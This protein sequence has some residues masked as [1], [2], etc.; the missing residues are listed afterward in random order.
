MSS[1]A[2]VLRNIKNK[3]VACVEEYFFVSCTQ[4]TNAITKKTINFH[5]ANFLASSSAN[6]YPGSRANASRFNHL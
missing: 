2:K 1:V 5:Q 6:K 4:S 3:N